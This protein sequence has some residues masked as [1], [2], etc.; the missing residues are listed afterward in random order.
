MTR[1]A[2]REAVVALLKNKTGAQ[3]RVFE[4]REVAWRRTE[5]PG[6]AVYTLEEQ[7]SSPGYEPKLSDRNLTLAVL[8]V[9]KLSEDVDDSLDAL[10]VEVETL[11]RA[12]PT[13]GGK[14]MASRYTGCQIEIAAEQ[15]R[16]LG[17]M[18]MTFEVRY[19]R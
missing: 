5:L 19:A 7:A 16:P 2:I 14:A 10:S 6:I 17:V 18:R 11:L 12:D 4:T 15:E 8:L 9:V 1:R 13:F 3:D